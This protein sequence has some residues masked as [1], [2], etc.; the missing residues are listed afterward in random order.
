M[1]ELDRQYSGWMYLSIFNLISLIFIVFQKEITLWETIRDNLPVKLFVSFI[2]WTLLTSLF[3]ANYIESLV[4][5]SKIVQPITFIILAITII[6]SNKIKTTRFLL[7]VGII[8]LFLENLTLILQVY[9]NPSLSRITGTT[10]NQNIAVASLNVKIPLLFLIIF[11]NKFKQYWLK[12]I[13]LILFFS[14]AYF[15]IRIGSKAGI[16]EFLISVSLTLVYLLRISKKNLKPF[17]Y[18][19]SIGVAIFIIKFSTPII[20]SLQ[21]TVDYK[22]EQGSVDRI[23]YYSQALNHMFEHPLVGTGIGSWKIESLKYDS[24]FMNNYVVQYHTHNDILQFG[25]E[26]G[27]I[28]A[29][30][31]LSIFLSLFLKIVSGLKIKKGNMSVNFTLLSMLIVYLIDLNLNFPFTRPIMHLN[32]ALIFLILNSKYEK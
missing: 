9:N 16:L 19:F 2:F 24:K 15:I 29:L 6:N 14:S 13:C 30:L 31:F 18:V 4:V 10:A 7:L 1:G 22:N 21:A 28:G 8:M 23:R 17:F 26:T 27:I 5:I 20:N 11:G 32:L 3:S 12:F 25:A